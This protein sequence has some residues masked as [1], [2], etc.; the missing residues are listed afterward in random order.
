MGISR[1]RSLN[2]SICFLSS[3]CLFSFFSHAY[4]AFFP[5][6]WLTIR[7]VQLTH[8]TDY[9]AFSSLHKY[10][11]SLHLCFF[12]TILL[13]SCCYH[14][15]DCHPFY[16]F[17]DTST[18]LLLSKSPLLLSVVSL[19]LSLIFI[20]ILCSDMAANS[21]LNHF[22]LYPTLVPWPWCHQLFTLQN[23]TRVL[24]LITPGI[25]YFHY[26]I[27]F[28]YCKLFFINAQLIFLCS[29]NLYFVFSFFCTWGCMALP[30]F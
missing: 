22:H 29:Q 13:P 24:L 4:F 26:S 30:S 17:F 6:S 1:V 18:Y 25:V 11:G 21:Q 15:N 14:H 8:P 20:I 3:S 28:Y 5:P 23:L 16:S 19:S 9:L 10:Y 12:S 2:L 27:A 7:G